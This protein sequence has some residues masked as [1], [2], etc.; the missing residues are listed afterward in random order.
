MLN[1]KH[2]KV[3]HYEPNS[4]TLFS[5]TE[6]KGG[7]VISL[8]ETPI[9]VDTGLYDVKT[10]K[11]GKMKVVQEKGLIKQHVIIT[12]SRKFM[13]YQRAVRNAQIEHA[14]KM[15]ASSNP[16]DVKK[17]INDVRRFINAVQPENPVKKR[18][19]VIILTNP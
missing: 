17:G 14:K 8:L 2:F 10:C 7:I 4:A 18:L 5:N 15:L 19:T 16:E 12:F 1:D 13:E 6:I 3:L 9:Y 11:D